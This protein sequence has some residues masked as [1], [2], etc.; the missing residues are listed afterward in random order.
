MNYK[1]ILYVFYLLATISLSHAAVVVS[2]QT[3]P[4]PLFIAK[5]TVIPP[6]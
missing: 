3:T 1:A 2:A 4:N 5:T 6:V